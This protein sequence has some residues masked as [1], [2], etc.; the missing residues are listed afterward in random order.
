MKFE[1]LVKKVNPVLK[2][3]VYRLNSRLPIA[4]GDDLLQEA[5]IHLWQEYE[6]GNLQDKTDSYILQG[7]YFHLKNYLRK[8]NKR[9]RTVSLDEI[10]KDEEGSFSL[11]E[12]MSLPGEP[13]YSECLENRDLIEAINND[14]LTTR[15]KQIFNLSLTGRNV[16][17]IG[18]KIGISH[19]RVVKLMQSVKHKC[20]KFKAEF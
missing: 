11:K 13:S 2:R 16:R 5:L 9:V 19:V 20:K 6:K 10:I 12:T 18:K 15:E 4:D 8:V 3:I 17:E 14:G 7:C 1:L